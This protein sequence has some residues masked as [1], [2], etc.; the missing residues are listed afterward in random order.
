MKQSPYKCISE[1]LWT[2]LKQIKNTDP[3][4]RNRKSEQRHTE[5]KGKLNGNIKTEN[6]ITENKNSE[7]SI[8]GWMAGTEKRNKGMIEQ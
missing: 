5:Y 1:Q 8:K 4:P 7:D 6:T 2:W 3:Q